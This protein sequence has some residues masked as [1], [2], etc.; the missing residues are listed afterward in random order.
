MFLEQLVLSLIDEEQRP[1]RRH[2]NGLPLMLAEMMSERLDRRPGG[3]RIVQAAACVGRSFR[4]D[5][6]SAVLDEDSNELANRLEGLV[7]AEILLPKRYGAEIRYEFRHSLLQRMAYDSMVQVERRAMHARMVAVLREREDVSIPEVIAHHLTEAGA[8][9]EAVRGWLLAGVNAAKRSAHLEAID[10]LRRGIELLGKIPEADVRRELELSLQAGLI[11]SITTT[12]GATSLELAT[13]CERG[14]QLCQEGSSSP[15]VFPFIFGQFTFANC[16]GRTAKSAWLAELFLHLAE[17]ASYDSGRVIGHRLRGMARLGEGKIA[18]A[19]EDLECSLALYSPERDAAST[20][21]FGQNTQVHSQ[22]LLSLTLFCLGDVNS[23]LQVG[24]DALAAADA[25]HH[26][27]STAMALVMWAG[28]SSDYVMRPSTCFARPSAWPP[29]PTAP[30]TRL[31]RARA[32][33][34]CGALCQR[35]E[36]DEGMASISNAIDTFDR[37]E[38]RLAVS[39]YLTNLAD[40]Q[41]RAGRMKEAKRSSVRALEMTLESVSDGTSPKR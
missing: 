4:A 1:G 12:Q 9:A 22:A 27:H 3:R 33:L 29:F 34:C 35:G 5:F 31:Q 7:D 37:A 36:L 24:R 26:P 20:H 40:A 38:Y 13:C 19:K 6:L 16:R 2:T 32:G 41:R 18:A 25:L 23:A 10:H 15:L 14:L 11:G 39:G 28:G 30:P 21:M 8:F 17:G